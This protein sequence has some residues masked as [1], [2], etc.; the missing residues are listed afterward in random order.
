MYRLIGQTLSEF[1]FSQK[2]LCVTVVCLGTVIADAK[3]LFVVEHFQDI[4]GLL[5]NRLGF[6]DRYT[7]LP[8]SLTCTN[9]TVFPSL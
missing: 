6:V 3:S 5:S 4:L 9:Y 7:S 8:V 1:L 2:W